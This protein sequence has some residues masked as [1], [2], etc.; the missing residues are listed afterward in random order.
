M[1]KCV[2]YVYVEKKPQVFIRFSKGYITQKKK[3][4]DLNTIWC[5]ISLISPLTA[6][7][8]KYISIVNKSF[9]GG[10]GEEMKS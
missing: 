9:W 6:L 7:Y 10:R 1:Q 2:L 3:F 5:F 8:N 4:K